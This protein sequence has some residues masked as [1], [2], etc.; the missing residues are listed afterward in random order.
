M[1]AGSHLKLFSNISSK[2]PDEGGARSD[3]LIALC[4]LMQDQY[5]NLSYIPLSFQ[6]GACPRTGIGVR[7]PHLGV[8]YLG[9]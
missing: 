4:T 5:R 6:H 7:T 2:S 8:L 3:I 9:V 1:A